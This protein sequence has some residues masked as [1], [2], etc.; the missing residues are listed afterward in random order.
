[1]SHQNQVEY[2]SIPK[3]EL[4]RFEDDPSS[5]VTPDVKLTV[6]PRS[7]VEPGTLVV[8]AQS[9]HTDFRC[10]WVKHRC[11]LTSD[12]DGRVRGRK[13]YA[14][15]DDD[16]ESSNI[17]QV[18]QTDYDGDTQPTF[19]TFTPKDSQGQRHIISEAFN[20]IIPD[21][22]FWTL[23]NDENLNRTRGNVAS[24]TGPREFSQLSRNLED[25]V[26]YLT[27]REDLFSEIALDRWTASRTEQTEAQETEIGTKDVDCSEQL[28]LTWK[29]RD[30]M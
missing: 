19:V 8:T 24:L 9:C 2:Q 3:T 25:A 29:S 4:I 14:I 10:H 30:I 21:P 26:S 6:I 15:I 12:D 28:I 18:I 1:M 16:P 7:A 20:T 23:N 22:T 13:R 11:F 27:N 5:P 17:F